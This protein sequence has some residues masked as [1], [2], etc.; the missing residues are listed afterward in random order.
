MVHAHYCGQTLESLEVYTKSDGCGGGECGDESEQSDSCCKDKVIA[1]KI[2]HDQHNENIYHHSFAQQFD[3]LSAVLPYA[4]DIVFSAI[5][6]NAINTIHAPN[7][8]PGRW[9][10]IALHKL[11]CR[12][13]YYG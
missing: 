6:D 7:A 2:T 3:I 13:T 12:F 5:G 4:T 8:P 10:N 1:A 9:Q 11:H